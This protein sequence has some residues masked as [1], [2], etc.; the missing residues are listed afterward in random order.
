MCIL[1]MPCLLGMAFSGYAQR[2]FPDTRPLRQTMRI[3]NKGELKA[4]LTKTFAMD[5]VIAGESVNLFKDLTFL[6]DDIACVRS[7]AVRK[8]QTIQ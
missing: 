3:R 6:N 1:L 2:S 5:F 7:Q 8:G 4:L